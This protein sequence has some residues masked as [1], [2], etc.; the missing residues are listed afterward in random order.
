ME[1]NAASWSYPESLAVDLAGRTAPRRIH[2]SNAI[3]P[4]AF[5]GDAFGDG[6]GDFNM[7]MNASGD[8]NGRG[9]DRGYNR[10]AYRGYGYGAPD[11]YGPYGYAPCG[12]PYGAPYAPVAPLAAPLTAPIAPP[13][14]VA[15]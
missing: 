8:G 12:A 10:V 15:Q 2:S 3:L 1:C 14:P 13:A 9:W 7:D 5:F 6:T 11:G 4:L